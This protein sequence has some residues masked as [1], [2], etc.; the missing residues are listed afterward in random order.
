MSFSNV[1]DF[2][3][4]L[5]VSCGHDCVCAQ[6]AEAA[7]DNGESEPVVLKLLLRY[8]PPAVLAEL[9]QVHALLRDGK[10]ASITVGGKP[11]DVNAFLAEAARQAAE[12]PAATVRSKSTFAPM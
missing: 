2:A 11:F 4:A 6:E 8:A 5:R 9:K 7:L 10:P 3:E 12:D 1:P